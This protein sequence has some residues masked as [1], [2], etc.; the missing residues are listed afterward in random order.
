VVT[1]LEASASPEGYASWLLGETEQGVRVAVFGALG[2]DVTSREARA[3]G[4]VPAAEQAPG[5]MRVVGADHLIGFEA[6]PA[7]HPIEG[8]GFVLR[9]PSVAS[10]LALADLYGDPADAIV[11][12]AWG[13]V[14][15]SHVLALRGL[16][17]ERAWVV[18]PFR[19]VTRALGLPELPAPDVTSEGGRRVALFVIEADGLAEHARLRGRPRTAAVLRNEILER[20][21]WPHALSMRGRARSAR[22]RRAVSE[23]LQHPAVYAAPPVLPG[24]SQHPQLEPSLTELS[25][26]TADFTGAP[27][28]GADSPIVLPAA[29]AAA[30]LRGAREAYPYRA[31]LRGLAATESPRRLTPLVLVYPAWLVASPGGSGSLR[32]I[33]DWIAQRPIAP[34]ALEAYAARLAAFR[35]QV[36]ARDLDGSYRLLGGEALRTIRVADTLG[37]VDRDRS[38]S[39]ASVTPVGAATYVTF[40]AGTRRLALQ[41]RA[42]HAGRNVDER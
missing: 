15:S 21:G 34:I 2:F 24:W 42:D 13:G 40:G 27:A 32:A 38:E 6:P 35:E 11:T 20:Y 16:S 12:T 7:R 25:G 33:Y 41:A 29:P 8:R 9:G 26:S 28:V 19:F 18:D 10:H 3:L 22:D 36:L 1:C 23:L 17:G 37:Q 5:H 30:Y 39:I 31:L 14:A 4:F